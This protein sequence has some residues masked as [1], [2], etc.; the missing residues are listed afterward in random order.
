MNGLKRIF[1][2]FLV[3]NE[4][5]LRKLDSEFSLPKTQSNLT[6]HQK[7]NRLFRRNNRFL[8]QLK[9]YKLKLKSLREREIANTVYTGSLLNQELHSVFPETTGNP[10]SN[11]T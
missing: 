8:Y 2:N 5:S 1:A 4:I 11:Q 6:Q 10:L 7:N 3:E 9:I